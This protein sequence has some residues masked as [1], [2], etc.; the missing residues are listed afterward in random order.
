MLGHSPASERQI[1]RVQWLLPFLLYLLHS[2]LF[3]AWVVDDAGIS[4]AYARNLAFGHG[5]VAQPGA[6]PVEGYSNFLWVV[7]LAPFFALRLFHPIITPKV[8]SVLIVLG[9][10]VLVDRALRVYRES[11]RLVTFLVLT[12]LAL[13]TTFVV[14]TVS[15]LETA[16]YVLLIFL[17][18]FECLKAVVSHSFTPR[19]AIL[20]GII[21]GAIAMTRPEGCLYLVAYPLVWCIGLSSP[22]DALRRRALANPAL[23]ALVFLAAYGGFLLFRVLYFHDLFPNAYYAKGGPGVRDWFT[24]GLLLPQAMQKLLF[25][26]MRTVAGPL[27]TFVFLGLVVVTAYVVFARAFRREH[28]VLLVFLGLTMAGYLLLPVNSLGGFR[29]GTP[30]LIFLYLYAAVICC[31]ALH[32]SGWSPDFKR[33]LVVAGLTIYFLGGV[34]MFG[35]LSLRFARNPVVPFSWGAERY[36]ARFNHYQD[37][38]GLRNASLLLP[39]LGGSLY[40]SRLRLYDLG[41]LCDKEMPRAMAQGPAAVHEYVFERLKPTFI[42]AHGPWSLAARFD[43]DPR[44]RQEYVPIYEYVDRNWQPADGAQGG[45]RVHSGEFVRRDVL[46]GKPALLNE[47][48]ACARKDNALVAAKWPSM[49]WATGASE[50]VIWDSPASAQ[51]Q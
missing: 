13:N 11:S 49:A 22:R 20:C 31:A 43:T 29:Y 15:G 37:V 30:V 36:G 19:T 2:A 1:T 45:L 10:F 28:A 47:L 14:W 7:L 44:F 17:L 39:D 41:C 21:S 18:F 5:L 24:V 42:V 35:F 6:A 40:A 27:G 46:K 4:Y 23:F 8:I 12:S 34:A 3:A 38:C 9:T 51:S 32:D 25:L 50:G 33:R 26:M 16:L 48:R